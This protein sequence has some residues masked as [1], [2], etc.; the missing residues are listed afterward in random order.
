MSKK[1]IILGGYGNAGSPIAH[2]L[3]QETNSTITLA[4][5][6]LEK[7]SQAAIELNHRFDSERVSGAYADAA[8][9]ESMLPLFNQADLVIVAASSIDYAPQ[10]IHAALTANIDYLDI[11]LSSSV[12]L[13]S[14]FDQKQKILEQ[15]RC[16]ITD[17][18]FHPGVPGALV[19]LS[20]K[21]F[22]KLETALVS[23]AFQMDWSSLDF[24]RSTLLEFVDEIIK[25]E[26]IHFKDGQWK[27]SRHYPKIYFGD[28]F[29]H[30]YCTPMMLEELRSLPIEILTLKETGFY[31][32]GFNWFTDYLVIPMA[33]AGKFFGKRVKKQIGQLF[34]WSLNKFSK[35][36]YRAVL[37]VQAS[38]IKSNEQTNYSLKLSHSDPYL[39]TA[40][41]VVACL[42]QYFDHSKPGIH[43]QSNFVEPV[44]F[45]KD[46]KRLGIQLTE[47]MDAELSSNKF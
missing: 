43:F 41:P 44:C 4:G 17:G 32:A 11:Q 10:V 31:I 26:P 20:S 5:R 8:E 16:F 47:S 29:G 7:A 27:K 12:K 28:P 14:L 3:L 25:Y 38:G 24:S 34:S 30:K 42:L 33:F 15:G 45:F 23:A 46:L 2:L 6:S 1:I 18:G 9:L 19:R 35:P 40:I 22:T 37:Q 21:K 39:L 13:Q 36:P